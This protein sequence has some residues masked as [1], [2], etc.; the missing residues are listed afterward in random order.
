MLTAL[1]ELGIRF[2]T[3]AKVLMAHNEMKQSRRVNNAFRFQCV[4]F[5]SRSIRALRALTKPPRRLRRRSVTIADARCTGR[6][7]ARRTRRNLRGP[8]GFP[9]R[10]QQ[11][12][13]RVSPVFRA[14]PGGA[15]ADRR[16]SARG[17]ELRR[18]KGWAIP[19]PIFR[20]HP[21]IPG[22]PP[23]KRYGEAIRALPIGETPT[24]T[25][26]EPKKSR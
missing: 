24:W 8:K 2:K 21:R 26:H 4:S 14:P 5:G 12:K 23:G 19:L 7:F 9:L 11:S 22:S 1:A 10:P 3:E 15:C 6:N 18:P 25:M 16:G 17:A 13:N 20:L